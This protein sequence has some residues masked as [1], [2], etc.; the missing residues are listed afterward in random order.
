[1]ETP[2]SSLGGL[3]CFLSLMP[4]QLCLAEGQASKSF[5]EAHRT[6]DLPLRWTWPVW[7]ATHQEGLKEPYYRH[8]WPLRSGYRS[9]GIS[10]KKP[11]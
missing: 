3:F 2:L 7:E 6:Q 11:G 1:M 8:Q 5:W 4:S 9:S 10:L